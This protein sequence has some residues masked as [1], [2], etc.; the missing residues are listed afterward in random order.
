MTPDDIAKGL[1]DTD[2]FANYNIRIICGW[3]DKPLGFKP[4]SDPKQHDKISHGMCR[5]CEVKQYKDLGMEPPPLIGE[6][7]DDVDEF[8]STG[9]YCDRCD[10]EVG[11]GE[12]TH[13]DPNE[14]L[15]MKVCQTCLDILNQG[16][17]D[18]RWLGIYESLDDT[19]EFGHVQV[20]QC[21]K[22]L[23]PDS[24]KLMYIF[25]D[26]TELYWFSNARRSHRLGFVW[27]DNVKINFVSGESTEFVVHPEVTI[28]EQAEPYMQG[29]YQ[30]NDEQKPFPHHL[31]KKWDQQMNTIQQNAIKFSRSLPEST[32]KEDEEHVG[33]LGPGRGLP[34]VSPEILIQVLNNRK[35]KPYPEYIKPAPESK[36]EYKAPDPFGHLDDKDEFDAYDDPCSEDLPHGGWDVI[37]QDPLGNNVTSEFYKNYHINLFTA[38]HPH[39]FDAGGC[40]VWMEIQDD[41]TGDRPFPAIYYWRG[42]WR[43]EDSDMMES[44][45]EDL[46]DKDEFGDSRPWV[47]ITVLDPSLDTQTAIDK[48]LL[49]L[50][51]RGYGVNGLDVTAW[52]PRSN[53]APHLQQAEGQ[54]PTSGLQIIEGY[55]EYDDAQLDDMVNYPSVHKQHANL[56]V[57]VDVYVGFLQT[58]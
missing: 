56:Q 17:A 21:Y 44:I 4:T 58:S 41:W 52:A 1:D 35:I 7:L 43:N 46:D 55:L 12:L 51:T 28:P 18:D 15:S 27:A 13:T 3:C 34:P 14:P 5:N 23:R 6:G 57:M 9:L 31:L 26:N 16:P 10:A 8:E 37:L 36:P 40:L 29:V 47:S 2:Q 33:A 20:L 42:M 39:G 30:F 48:A 24:I 25:E 49:L 19:D 53:V 45:A 32:I 22:E 50:G 38:A 54:I 11:Y